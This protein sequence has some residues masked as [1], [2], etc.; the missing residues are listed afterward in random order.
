MRHTGERYE[1]GLPW[2]DDRPAIESDRELCL[3]RLHSLHNRLKRNER[4][5]TEYDKAIKEQLASGIIEEIP[6]SQPHRQANV[7]HSI[8]H[9]AVI[10]EDKTTTKIRDYDGSA[11]TND[12][13]CSLN[14]CLPTGPN[15]VP[16]LFNILVK[17]RAHRVGLIANIEKAFLMTGID[18]IDRDM[19]R[20]LWFENV[21]DPIPKVSK[22][23]LTRLMFGL[24]SSPAIL[25]ATINHHLELYKENHPEM[26]KTIKDSL[27]V[28]DLVSRASKDDR[29]SEIY[30]NS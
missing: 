19:M 1:V 22:F 2:K 11:T 26:V 28:D 10:R 15:Y 9:H 23:R 17:F 21:H 24:R 29:A 14:D 30:Q 27:Y 18:E 25:G 5:L 16:Q 13:N 20:F 7:V 6:P 8:P 4:L 12:R 3:S